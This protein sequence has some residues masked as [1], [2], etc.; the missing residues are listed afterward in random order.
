[1]RQPDS[2]R[3]TYASDG[4]PGA[5]E[6]VDTRIMIELVKVNQENWQ[7][8]ISL[9]TSEAHRWVASN[10]YS[11][12]EAQFYPKATAYC[13]YAGDQMV[14]F[15]MYGTHEDDESTLWIDR[16]MIAEPHRGKGYGK[17]VLQRIIEEAKSRGLSRVGLST[18]AGN[19]SAKQVFERVGFRATGE[20]DG[21]EDIYIYDI[22]D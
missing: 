1:M 11:I 5:S 21:D 12:A 20:K 19:T 4:P 17:A 10:L 18:G 9:P 16:L 7:D 8:C 22:A 14:G 15:T 13:I 3:R 6:Q 2:I